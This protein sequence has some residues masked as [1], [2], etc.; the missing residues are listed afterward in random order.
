MTFA[1]QDA[2]LMPSNDD[3][4]YDELIRSIPETERA[5]VLKALDSDVIAKRADQLKQQLFTLQTVGQNLSE[6]R[7][8]FLAAL[9]GVKLKQISAAQLATL[10]ILDSAIRTLYTNPMMYLV[11]KYVDA[12]SQATINTNVCCLSG[13][14]GI[15]SSMKRFPYK[16]TV[17]PKENILVVDLPLRMQKP[18]VRRFFNLTDSEW[19]VFCN[20]MDKAPESEQCYHVLNAPEA[21]CWSNIT[22]RIQKLLKCMRVLDWMV[23]SKNE[24][25]LE[26]SIMVVPSFTMFQAALDAKAHTLARNPVQLIPTYGY[27]EAE[28]YAELKASGKIALALYLPERKE[29]ERYQPLVGNFRTRIDGHSCE[30]AF[31]GAIHDVYHALR[32]MAMSEN[33][34]KAR[35]R[36]ASIAKTHPKN[37]MNPCGRAVDEVLVD[38]ELIHS[39]PP[40]M[41]TVFVPEYRSE[42]A[43][44][45]GMIF[46]VDTVKR[47]LHEDLKRAFIE[48][49]VS[50]KQLWLEQFGLS[51]SDLLADDQSI[52]DDIQTEQLKRLNVHDGAFG[53]VQAMSEIGFLADH[54]KP[55]LG[56]PA[57][58]S[59]QKVLRLMQN[60]NSSMSI[61]KETAEPKANKKTRARLSS[62]VSVRELWD[63]PNKKPRLAKASDLTEAHFERVTHSMR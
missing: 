39:Y 15:P 57:L 2:S 52:Y 54:R 9:R 18:L 63:L 45:F 47:V 44:V 1:K 50:N 22:F 16:L 56:V 48:D 7:T 53:T 11:Y 61:K 58:N 46:Y 35:M 12:N 34:A 20:E 28:H 25:L 49:M 51:Q 43:D 40:H 59:T 31:C 17:L 62:E 10:H 55:P 24:G 13:S 21:G 3:L 30:T 23:D 41:D 38:G 29:E 32:E 19:A 42:Q 5:S 27:I 8:L 36:L 26:E 14:K 37:K 6:S 4:F 60:A 33:V